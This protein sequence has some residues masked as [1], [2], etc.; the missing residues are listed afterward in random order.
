MTYD[1]F[2]SRVGMALQ[3]ALGSSPDNGPLLTA[4][5]DW[6]HDFSPEAGVIVDGASIDADVPAN[7][8]EAGLGV[9]WRVGET[10]L[11]EIR[12]SYALAP[13]E[14]LADNSS[15]GASA[16]LRLGF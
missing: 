12:A 10:S 14:I 6:I 15:L 3:A 4:S 5:L 8:L 7:W 16:N 11:L 2:T 1:G 13:G 9:D